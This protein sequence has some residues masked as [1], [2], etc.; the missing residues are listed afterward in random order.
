MRRISIIV[1]AIMA[2]LA[3]GVETRAQ[4]LM[5]KARE[6][7]QRARELKKQEQSRYNTVVDS[8]DLSKYRQFISDY[9][10]SSYTPEIKRRADEIRL[11]NSARSTNT[12]ASYESYIKKSAYHWYDSQAKE[13]IESLRRAQEK[14]AWEA[15]MARNTI[16]AYQEYLRDNPNTGYRADAERAIN[17]LQ[18]AAAWKGVAASGTLDD[19]LNFVARYPYAAEVSIAEKH[20]HELR[21]KQYY[22]NNNLSA[23]YNEFSNLSRAD[24]S[25]ENKAAYDAAVEYHEYSQLGKYSSESSLQSFLRRYPNSKYYSQVSNLLAI[26]KASALGDYASDSDYNLALSYARDEKTRNSVKSYIEQN[27]NK[28]KQREREWKSWQ[29]ERNGG[30][31]NLGLD[32]MDLGYN[33][34]SDEGSILYYNLGLMLRIGNYAD[35]VQFAVGLKP[36]II[37]YDRFEEYDYYYYDYY[38]EEGETSFHMPIVAQLKLNLFKTSENSRFF[39]YGQY[40]YNTVRVED[41]ES[42]MSWCAGAGIGWKH[43]DMSM[44]YR[45]DIGNPENDWYSKQ[46]YVGLSL[47]Y[48]WKL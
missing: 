11:W 4:S 20:I 32:F 17:R 5:Q 43:F 33:C 31:F 10:Y 29:R 30:T 39:V 12:I 2:M 48:Y 26:S 47:I 28:Q 9:P 24:V 44:Y 41:I 37:Y 46:N 40:Q 22:L 34:E 45:K 42:E 35:R 19:Y 38:Y 13:N 8:R 23:A 27:K 14:K 18:G 25:Y 15:V 3:A 6:A 1:I 36:G 16:E 7:E 21:G